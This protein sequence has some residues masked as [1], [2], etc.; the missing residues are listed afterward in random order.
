MSDGPLNK[1]TPRSC[2]TTT[3]LQS[4]VKERKCTLIVIVASNNPK[5]NQKMMHQ[6]KFDHETEID[7]FYTIFFGYLELINVRP[8]SH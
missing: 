7:H 8:S 3:C 5:F 1:T 4:F 2:K 6:S